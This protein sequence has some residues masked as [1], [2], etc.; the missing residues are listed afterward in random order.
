MI[1]P[2]PRNSSPLSRVVE[3]FDLAH[4]LGDFVNRVVALLG[5]RA[6]ARLAEARD[7]DFHP[8]ALAAEDLAVGRVGHHDHIGP[9]LVFVHDVLPAKSVAVFFHHGE[10]RE[11]A[12]L[13]HI[14][15]EV[16]KNLGRVDHRGDRPF[17]VPC[18][19]APHFAVGDFAFVRIVLPF[20]RACRRPPYRRGHRWQSVSCLCRACRLVPT[21]CLTRL[22][23]SCRTRRSPP[24][25]ADPGDDRALPRPIP[26]GSRPC[27]GGSGPSAFHT[28]GRLR[29]KDSCSCQSFV[30]EFARIP[31]DHCACLKSCDFSYR[32]RTLERGRILCET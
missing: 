23:R 15:L 28:F 32:E 8:A 10:G 18:P 5:H 29:N 19:A 31:T 30:A 7:A 24:F 6:V 3:R 27:R 21:D 22:S 11:Q 16:A 17:L 9:N 25:P 4:D 14:D 12:K 1:V 2:L 26:R 13:R 20:A